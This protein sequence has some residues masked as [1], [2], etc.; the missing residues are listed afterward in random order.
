MTTNIIKQAEEKLILIF[1]KLEETRDFNQQKVLKAFQDIRIG[2]EHFASVSGYGHDDLG[3]DAIDRVFAQI[4]N[5]EKAVV[6]NQFVSGTHALSCVLFG[7]LRSGDKLVS[8]AGRPYDTMEEVIGIRGNKR[9]SL[10]GHGIRYDEVPLINNGLDID[11]DGVAKTIDR[12][13]S[14]ILIQRSCGYDVRKVINI[15]LMKEIISIAKNKNPDCICFVDNCYGE[16]VEKLE[17]IDIGADIIGGSLIKNPGGGLV[18]TGGYVAGKKEYV[19]QAAMRLTAP[20]IGSEGG[21]MLNQSRLIL[22]GL[23]MAPSIVHDALKGAILAAEVFTQ[24]GF[25]TAP[26]SDELRSDII[27]AIEFGAPEPLIRFCKVLQY[28]S[29][30]NS[31]LTPIPDNVPGYDDK[32]IMAGGSFIE[33]ATIELSADGPIRP[34]YVAYMQGGLNYAHVKLVIKAIVEELATIN[35]NKSLVG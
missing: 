32:L 34:P 1:K 7:N 23:F 21:A 27:Q 14:M 31:H 25:K 5:A 26:A 22:Q 8:I 19:E 9:A 16:F 17:P 4:F 18:E 3:R 13:T 6:R 15:G 2:E 35:C 12:N 10:M 29:P 28:N 24:I 20:G 30:V 11:L 33:G